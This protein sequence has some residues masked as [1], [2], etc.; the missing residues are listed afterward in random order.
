MQRS[1]PGLNGMVAAHGRSRGLPV[2]AIAIFGFGL[3]FGYLACLHGSEI[4]AKN[5]VAFAVWSAVAVL[6]GFLVTW[7][8]KYVLVLAVLLVAALWYTNSPSFRTAASEARDVR[9]D[10]CGIMTFEFDGLPY[11]DWIC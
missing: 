6:A 3:L 8:F 7:F 5:F 10:L 1:D 2:G 9:G 11:K 4:D